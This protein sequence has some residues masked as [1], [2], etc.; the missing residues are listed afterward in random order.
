MTT[1]EDIVEEDL[2]EWIADLRRSKNRHFHRDRVRLPHTFGRTSTASTAVSESGQSETSQSA[3]LMATDEDIVE[4]DLAQWIAD[5]R[6]KNQH[7][8]RDRVRFGR[9]SIASTAVSESGQSETSQPASLMTTDSV[10]TRAVPSLVSPFP[11]DFITI[12]AEQ[13]AW[14]LEFLSRGAE[15]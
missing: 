1:D 6:R 8:H 4:E 2:A 10:G 11:E 14:E 5:I 12:A 3:S 7:F 15:S 9:T 13:N